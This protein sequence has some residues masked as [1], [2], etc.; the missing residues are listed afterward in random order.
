MIAAQ[1]FQLANLMMMVSTLIS[2]ASMVYVTMVI[3][4]T[5]IFTVSTD[6]GNACGYLVYYLFQYPVFHNLHLHPLNDRGT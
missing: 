4:I 6:F 2:V 5:A 1:K 3:F